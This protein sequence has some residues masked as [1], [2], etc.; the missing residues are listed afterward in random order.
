M[1]S[2]GS[3]CL[4][5]QLRTV[6][7]C[8]TIVDL[9]E[10]CQPYIYIKKKSLALQLSLA[11]NSCRLTWARLQ[12]P[13]EQ[14]YP[15]LTLHAVFS[16]V[17]TKVWL[18]VLGIFNVRRM[19]MHANAPGGSKDTERESALKVDW[20]KNPS[21]HRRIEPASAACQF[22]GLPT[23]LHPRPVGNRKKKKKSGT[24]PWL[25]WQN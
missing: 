15:F 11:G 21:P 1:S 6:N 16:C 17:Q 12:Q 23:E 7:L 2:S 4:V 20:E 24:I 10:H 18:P 19:L 25:P 5:F 3:S 9:V 8:Q 14:R 13:Q 22:D